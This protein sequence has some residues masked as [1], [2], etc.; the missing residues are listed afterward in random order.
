[1]S[2]RDILIPIDRLFKQQGIQYAVI[3][4]YAVAA[5]GEVRA[6]RDVDLYCAV[7][8]LSAVK[9][10]LAEG[11]IEFG[12]RAGDHEDPISDVIRIRAASVDDPFEID[13]LLGIR[14]APQGLLSRAREVQLQDLFLRV[15]SPEDMIVLKLLGG[16]SRDLDDARSIIRVQQERLDVSLMMQLCPASLKDELENLLRPKSGA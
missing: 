15:A 8:D 11:S 5:W 16:S 4:G 2:L 7:K 9:S 12:H 13:I 3:G 14:G 10:A 1:M 6:T